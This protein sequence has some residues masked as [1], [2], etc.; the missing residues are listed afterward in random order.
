MQSGGSLDQQ[1]CGS[2]KSATRHLY[3][4]M[5]AS[6]YLHLITLGWPVLCMMESTTLSVQPGLEQAIIRPHEPACSLLIIIGLSA[7]FCLQGEN[8]LV[9]LRILAPLPAIALTEIDSV[10]S[11][12]AHSSSA[13]LNVLPDQ[14]SEPAGQAAWLCA[15]ASSPGWR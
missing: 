10:A 15:K 12:L 13:P 11:E 6:L 4:E 9:D 3:G 5:S 8:D 14:V 7:E 1:H 2:I